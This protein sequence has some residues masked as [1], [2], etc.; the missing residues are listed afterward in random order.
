MGPEPSP[1]R[2]PRTTTRARPRPS[3]EARSASRSTS[4]GSTSP[5]S[6]RP[7]PIV[8]A[9]PSA[10]GLG[11]DRRQRHRVAGLRLRP[12]RPRPAGAA[13]PGEGRRVRL[14]IGH[15]HRAWFL[16]PGFGAPRSWCC[17][18]GPPV[19]CSSSARRRDSW[20]AAGLGRPVRRGHA[21]VLLVDGVRRRTPCKPEFAT[22]GDSLWWGI[23]TLTTVGY[24]DIVP[25]TEGPAGRCLPH[26]DGARHLGVLSGTWPAPSARPAAPRP[27][28]RGRP[29][30]GGGD[31]APATDQPTAN[32][33][34]TTDDLQASWP[35][36]G[37]TSSCSRSTSRRSSSAAARR[38]RAS[39]IRPLLSG[40]PP[41][42]RWCA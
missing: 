33:A 1:E 4:G 28:S 30:R 22:F 25:E 14:V 29:R 40:L 23:V 13:L 3:P 19:R 6:S 32:G 24:G 35:T 21:A 27:R 20:S 2:S 42:L 36:C 31:E 15:H 10:D 11:V 26:A 12:V 34:A 16:I 37:P 5:C 18:P 17:P 8:V 38:R 9:R 39:A 41:H 7:P